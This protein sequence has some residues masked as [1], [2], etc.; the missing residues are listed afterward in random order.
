MN[1]DVPGFLDAMYDFTA[2]G[3]IEEAILTF[4]FDE[5]YKKTDNFEPAIY[6]IDTKN[7]EMVL[8]ETQVIDW[9]KHTVTV[10][11]NH[12]SNYSLVEKNLQAKAWNIPIYA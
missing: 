1:E 9:D 7:Q 8:L 11:V 2:S 5:K 4:K 12:F 3:D 10:K 6:Y